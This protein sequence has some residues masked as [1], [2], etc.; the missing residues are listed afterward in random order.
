MYEVRQMPKGYIITAENAQEIRGKMDETKSKN[1][2]R[3]LEVVALRGE[4]KNNKEIADIMKMN[5]KYVS[6][7]VSLY[8]N[9]GLERLATDER[10]GGNHRNMTDDEEREFLE[11]F[12]K[13]A[14]NGQI[15][16][17]KEMTQAY[18]EKIGKNRKK[19]IYY[20]LHKHEWRKI[21]PRPRHPKKATDEEI[22]SSKK[23]IKNSE[24]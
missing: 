9:F 14:E 6:Q 23:L 16:T 12:R 19:G 17:V 22:E 7:L 21:A 18:C 24:N 11:G 2:Y 3:R 20:L 1:I 13:Q 15:V 5:Q 4:G 10:K 8:A